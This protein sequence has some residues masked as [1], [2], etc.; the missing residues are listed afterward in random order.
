M[1]EKYKIE[2]NNDLPIYSQLVAY[3]EKLIVTNKLL[4]KEKIPSVRELALL[5]KVNPN[6]VQKAL[7]ELEQKGLIF[8]K[9]TN[10]KFVCEDESK[11]KKFKQELIYEKIKKFVDEMHKL[12]VS[13]EE[14]IKL[15]K[16]EEN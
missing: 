7:G 2:F 16:G 14:I 3:M 15:V 6:T 1:S 8:T 5:L 9:R 11:I 12:Q 10:G 13:D 4:P